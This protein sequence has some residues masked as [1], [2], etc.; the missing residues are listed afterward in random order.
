[1][2][3]LNKQINNPNLIRKWKHSELP[4]SHNFNNKT[5]E[6]KIKEEKQNLKTEQKS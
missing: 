2:T 3:L 4:I 5:K 6:K 1:M